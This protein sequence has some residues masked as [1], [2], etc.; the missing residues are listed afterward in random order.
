MNVVKSAV[1]YINPRQKPVIT[2]DHPLFA[3][4]KQFNGTRQ[5]HMKRISS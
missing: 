2:L 4:A 3:I 1:Q 5:Y